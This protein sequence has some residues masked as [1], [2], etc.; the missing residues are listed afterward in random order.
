MTDNLELKERIVNVHKL[1]T[2]T[3]DL[4]DCCYNSK[5]CQYTDLLT[6]QIYFIV[7]DIN[8]LNEEVMSG[9]ITKEMAR[10]NINYWLDESIW[11]DAK[12]LF[13][14]NNYP[15][16]SMAHQKLRE[17]M[18]SFQKSLG[19]LHHNL[20]K[21]P[22]ECYSRFLDDCHVMC[23]DGKVEL[24]YEHHMGTYVSEGEM[25]QGLQ[26][27]LQRVVYGLFERNFL[28]FDNCTMPCQH[29]RKFEFDPNLLS[30]KKKNS[31]DTNL[32]CLCLNRYLIMPDKYT[33]L[34]N[35][36]KAGKY[37][38]DHYTKLSKD[39]FLSISYFG[40]ALN[41]YNQGMKETGSIDVESTDET[42][43]NNLEQPVAEELNYF[44]PQKNLQKLLSR[45]WF[46]EVRMK[47]TYNQAWTDAFVEALMASEWRD[48]IARQWA[49]TG[50][51]SKVKQ[52]KGYVLGLLTDACVLRGSYNQVALKA[53]VT[54]DPRSF[55]RYMAEGKKQ[56]YAQWVMRYITEH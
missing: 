32:F 54:D 10:V 39:D 56:P 35:K 13:D 53:G 21:A 20:Q 4:L 52:I 37:L 40:P 48:D 3:A 49:I 30:S 36:E 11:S 2:H 18:I 42:E 1:I 25:L 9:H 43:K 12:K 47:E 22:A 50:Q 34:L 14:A 23:A 29:G 5:K 15:D 46:S 51:R 55:S 8:H 38:F 16:N 7:T 33:V 45:S 31:N 28:R 26:Y 41:K 19:L 27:Y 44:A 24:D 17:A 6:D